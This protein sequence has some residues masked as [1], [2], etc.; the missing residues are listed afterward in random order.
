M[1]PSHDLNESQIQIGTHN[2]IDNELM[3]SL[4]NL[5]PSEQAQLLDQIAMVQSG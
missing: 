5:T 1:E 4:L 2:D 3:N